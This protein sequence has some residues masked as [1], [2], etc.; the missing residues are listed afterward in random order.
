MRAC[1]LSHFSHVRLFMTVWTHSPPGPSVHGILQA[2][3]LEWVA[4]PSSRGSSRLRDWT[5]VPVSPAL[6]GGFFTTEPPRKPIPRTHA[7]KTFRM[8]SKDSDEEMSLKI[9]CGKIYLT[10]EISSLH[11]SAIGRYM[12]EDKEN[13]IFVLSLCWLP[14]EVS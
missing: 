7:Y 1:T 2:R 3:I 6:A 4:M 5:G 13:R 12:G 11:V 10:T 14:P 8:I 9:K